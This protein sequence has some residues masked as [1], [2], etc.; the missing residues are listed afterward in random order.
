MEYQDRL[1]KAV[2]HFWEVRT[3]QHKKQGSATGKKDAGNRS[4]VTGGK[5]LDGFI[6]LLTFN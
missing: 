6:T 5:H 4:A 1:A 3:Q 2:Q